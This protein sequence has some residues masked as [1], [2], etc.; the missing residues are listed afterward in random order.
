L[1]GCFLEAR[2]GTV[3]CRQ[4]A[5]RDASGDAPTLEIGS[6]THIQANFAGATPL[7]GPL[8]CGLVAT[9]TLPERLRRFAGQG[10]VQAF[11]ET[12]T[13]HGFLGARG[14]QRKDALAD[15]APA[16]SAGDDQLAYAVANNTRFVTRRA[17]AVHLLTLH[18]GWQPWQP[19]LALAV[20]IA[21]AAWAVG[22]AADLGAGA[23]A[24]PHYG[25]VE[26]LPT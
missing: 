16:A 1:S 21:F 9:G 24:R 22:V 4:Q 10:W 7:E 11:P 19:L 12:G 8:V 3:F 17:N 20:G 15:T 13:A 6:M 14:G 26:A 5:S 18:A 25:S 2:C 23:A